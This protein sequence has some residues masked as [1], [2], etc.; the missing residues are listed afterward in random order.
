[1]T[2]Q[3]GDELARRMAEAAD[4]RLTEMLTGVTRE[5]PS[6]A[7]TVNAYLAGN[8]TLEH[9]RQVMDGLEDRQTAL[10]VDTFLRWGEANFRAFQALRNGG[11]LLIGG[12][13]RGGSRG[14]AAYET[15]LRDAPDL[16]CH[17]TEYLPD[18]EAY[19]LRRPEWLPDVR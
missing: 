11:M 18:G 3:D 8:L 16:R 1:M 13:R 9:L 5:P 15:I 19:V 12:H 4:A 17:L 7:A 14:A 6:T 10:D 2:S